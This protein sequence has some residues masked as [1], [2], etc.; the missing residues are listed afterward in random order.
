MG[1]SNGE[2][3]III[4]EEQAFS[5]S[6]QNTLIFLNHRADTAISL[7]DAIVKIIKA[8][9]EKDPYTV[10]IVDML[11]EVTI[12]K[13][14]GKRGK[15]MIKYMKGN[16]PGIACI[17]LSAETP[18]PIE[19]LD[20]RDEFGLDYFLPKEDIDLATLDETIR[21]ALKHAAARGSAKPNVSE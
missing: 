4:D 3:I 14:K 21:K 5:T 6:L 19:L 15:E 20:M 11:F 8:F 17:L 7:E 10:A 18:S 1:T 2:R 12:S 13:I 16:F 9:N